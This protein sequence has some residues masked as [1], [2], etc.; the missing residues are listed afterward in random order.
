[1]VSRDPMVWTRERNMMKVD[2]VGDD[3]IARFKAQDQR[4]KEIMDDL[5]KSTGRSVD[6]VID[7]G[8]SIMGAVRARHD[9][10]QKA[11]SELYDRAR[12]QYG[13]IDGIGVS[14]LINKVDELGDDESLRPITN[15]VMNILKRRGLVD[16]DGSVTEKTLTVSQAEGIRKQIRN[17]G[18]NKAS[19]NWVKSQIIDQLDDDVFN[20]LGDDVFATARNTAKSRFR[21]FEQ[22][23]AD[24]IVNGK[25][26]DKAFDDIMRSDSSDIMALKNTLDR[27]PGGAQAWS[28]LKGQVIDMLNDKATQGMGGDGVFNGT[29]LKKALDKIGPKKLQAIFGDQ[30]D[31]LYQVSRV[32]VDMTREPA[33]SAVNYSNSAP[34]L[35]N[36]M[37][38]GSKSLP[39]VGDAMRQ[40]S[41]SLGARRLLD[42]AVDPV[43]QAA[44]RRAMIEQMMNSRLGQYA[45][46]GLPVVSA[47][48]LTDLSAFE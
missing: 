41:A 20:A 26:G 3:F 47:G 12:S 38:A 27:A 24:R 15:S 8:D 23:I 25:M 9:Q 32:G 48:L 1:Q 21:E 13:D 36:Y 28:N 11:V 22:K 33:W 2:G 29:Q 18:G 40:R 6:D 43:K 31:F 46:R 37:M 7:A 17:F 10:T 14:G 44:Q 39:F 35:M 19:D 45:N 16:A 4:F 5:A 30:A 34:A 42:N